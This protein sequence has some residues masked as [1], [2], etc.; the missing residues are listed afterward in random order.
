MT[1]RSEYEFFVSVP[2]GT[3]YADHSIHR[4]IYKCDSPKKTPTGHYVRCR[5]CTRCKQAKTYF[6]FFR[7]ISEIFNSPATWFLTLTYRQANQNLEKFSY[8]DVQKFLKRFRTHFSGTSRS[9]LRYLFTTETHKSGVLH[10]HALIH[11]NSDVSRRDLEE[12]WTNGFTK[13]LLVA[14]IKSSEKPHL[15]DKRIDFAS[16]VARRARY[17]SKYVSKSGRVRASQKYG[18]G[19]KANDYGLVE[20]STGLNIPF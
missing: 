15:T 4:G 19:F 16:D 17:V 13:C 11:V 18:M 2:R 20:C 3:P 12:I 9:K 7:S 10:Y 5:N 14:S 8:N 1:H 6:W